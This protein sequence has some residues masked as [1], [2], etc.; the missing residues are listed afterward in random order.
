MICQADL[1]LGRNASPVVVTLVSFWHF[2]VFRGQTLTPSIAFTS[3]PHIFCF[4]PVLFHNYSHNLAMHSRL[5]V[6]I[7][8]SYFS[9]VLIGTIFPS[10]YRDEIRSQCITG[11]LYQYASGQ[12][13]G[14]WTL[15]YM[16]G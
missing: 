8:V 3:V 6:I 16:F 14:L 7:N 10:L 12:D 1:S 13:L 15:H 4:C 5:Q 2:A 11:N 9:C